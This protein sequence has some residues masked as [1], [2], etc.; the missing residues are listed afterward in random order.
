MAFSLS[1]VS[2]PVRASEISKPRAISATR[3]D[4]QLAASSSTI[5]ILV[6]LIEVASNYA[7]AAAS[8]GA[9]TP[10]L[11]NFHLPIQAG[12]HPLLRTA[13]AARPGSPRSLHPTLFS[14]ST[15]SRRVSTDN[16]RRE[17]QTEGTLS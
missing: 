12:A 5:I 1:K 17:K 9:E 6:A 4:R 10:T 14:R 8:S 2:S 3:N 7:V 15:A 16:T 13:I 11:G